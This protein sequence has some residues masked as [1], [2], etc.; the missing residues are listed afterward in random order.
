[1]K[2]MAPGLCEQRANYVLILGLMRVFVSEL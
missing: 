1:M 2:Q